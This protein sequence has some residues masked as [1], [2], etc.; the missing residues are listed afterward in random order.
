MLTSKSL[1]IINDL[2]DRFYSNQAKYK[3]KMKNNENY[4]EEHDKMN[5]M[6][7][8]IAD[9]D[10]ETL[11]ALLNLTKEQSKVFGEFWARDLIRFN[12]SS[13]K[14]VIAAALKSDPLALYGAS[15]EITNDAEF[16]KWAQEYTHGCAYQYCGSELEENEEL[17]THALMVYLYDDNCYNIP[18]YLNYCYDKV[19]KNF[20]NDPEE[21][22]KA[23]NNITL[24]IASCPEENR[25]SL[26]N[27]L[28]SLIE[29]KNF[30]KDL[31]K[32]HKQ[33]QGYSL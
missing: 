12:Y 5:R 31:E 25:N 4:Q 13:D 26:E 17:A 21:Y 23:V 6:Y 22:D 30:H 16:M 3:S 7:V 18:K 20:I 29:V 10:K 14:E 32:I 24:K 28:K 1:K 8:E 15:E 19:L 33:T 2:S 9:L 27:K 11:I